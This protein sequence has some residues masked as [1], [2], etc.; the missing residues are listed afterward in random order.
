MLGGGLLSLSALVIVVTLCIVGLLFALFGVI[1]IA[2]TISKCVKIALALYLCYIVYMVY[3]SSVISS[4]SSKPHSSDQRSYTSSIHGTDNPPTIHIG[5]VSFGQK[6]AE[7]VLKNI[8]FSLLLTT[9][10]IQWYV[11]TIDNATDIIEAGIQSW[12]DNFKRRVSVVNIPLVCTKW[13]EHI[14]AK[15]L[16][17][18]ALK[19]CVISDFENTVLKD[20]T[21]KFIFIDLDTF[22]MDDLMHLWN[23]F[24][25]FTSDHI[26]S[27]ARA[28]FRYLLLKYS[29]YS[30][31]QR[32]GINTGVILVN[33]K[34]MAG[35][36]FEERYIGCSKEEIY[37]ESN[38]TR[39]IGKKDDQ[40]ILNVL[41]Y[42]YPYKILPLGCNWNYRGSMDL[43]CTAGSTKNCDEAISQGVSLIHTYSD[44]YLSN[45]HYSAVYKCSVDLDLNN[46]NETV[47]CLHA[48][49]QTFKKG[50]EKKCSLHVN[51]LGPLERALNRLYPGI[52]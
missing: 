33:F 12:P 8:Q 25:I 27:L 48:G 44:T 18:V 49:I 2:R 19:P 43:E 40:N 34:N 36:D 41:F 38:E 17:G 29:Q 30:Y 28:D 3:R 14:K 23:Y 20:H 32:Y 51:N 35:F 5:A 45:S 1:M 16:R 4:R 46:V 47:R 39:D 50:R 52:V 37:F 21:D 26:M 22:I 9:A 11:F 7:I 42:K 13:K 31:D 6:Y 10:N 24:S 15:V